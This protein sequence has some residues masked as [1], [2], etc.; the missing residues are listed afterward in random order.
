MLV[1]GLMGL[2]ACG[3]KE[4]LDTGEVEDITEDTS[5]EDTDETEETDSD[6]T[7]TEET[8]SDTEEPVDSA[9]PDLLG[10]FL[11]RFADSTPAPIV[12]EDPDNT[13][14]MALFMVSFA[15]MFEIQAQVSDPSVDVTCP[16]IQGTFPE[17]GLPTEPVT[18]IGNGCSN[19][20]G[21]TYDGSFVYSETGLVYTNY[22]VGV[23]NE[24]CGVLIV[25][26]YN[27]GTDMSIGFTGLDAESMFVVQSQELD[28]TNCTMT[29][30]ELGYHLETSIQFQD[31]DSQLI[32]GTADI[33]LAIEGVDYA[34]F[35]ETVDEVMDESQCVTEPISGTNT[36]GNGVDELRFTFDGATDCDEEP[37]Q[38][39]SVNGGQDSEVSG[40]S[41]SSA[42][43]QM[44][45]AWILGLL[46][47]L[48]FRKRK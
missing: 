13:T 22:Q 45:F 46:G 37:T 39:L 9:F 35:V 20:Q 38:M 24:A 10:P 16:E 14:S 2:L 36:I 17:D 1:F 34:Y 18:V 31:D 47:V 44:T 15:P 23:P 33:L 29:D 8:D 28:E 30:T 11:E 12:S 40:A 43:V 26:Q 27:G 25:S 19:E 3:E 7:D 41:C 21:V 48:S 4:T 42:P 6:D 32:N 5:V